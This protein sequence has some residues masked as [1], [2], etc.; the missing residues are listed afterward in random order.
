MPEYQS[1]TDDEVLQ[2][3]TEREQLTDD[4]RSMLDSELAL[5]KLSIKDV[6]SQKI[7]YERAEKLERA[8]LGHKILSQRTF[9]RRGFGINFFGKTN[10]RRDPAGHFE[11]YDATQ[12][13]VILWIPVFPVATCTVHRTRSRWLGLTF[14]SAPQIIARHARN[15]E[16]I[17]LTW[18][19]TAAILLGLRLVLL[20][21]EFHPDFLRRLFGWQHG[22]S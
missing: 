2:I 8:R 6:Q 16:Q 17:L 10:V 19:K 20:F 4:A 11:E 12:W 3:A 13:V 5:R 21:L 14:K 7:A 22:I 15:W 1:L 18:V 9:S